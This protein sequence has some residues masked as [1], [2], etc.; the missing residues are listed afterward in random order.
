MPFNRKEVKLAEDPIV[1]EGYNAQEGSPNDIALLK[2]FFLLGHD[3]TCSVFNQSC[4]SLLKMLTSP[5]TPLP[6]FL[7]LMMTTPARQEMFM[8]SQKAGVEPSLLENLDSRGL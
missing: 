7:N 2:V 4:S 5:C 3:V 1:H 8:V 6:A